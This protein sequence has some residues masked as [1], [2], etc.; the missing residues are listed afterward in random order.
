MSVKYALLGILSEKARHGYD[1]K[2]AFEERVGEFWSLNYGQI[3]QTLDRLERDGLVLR[4]EEP[5]ERRPDRKVYR[6]T[7]KGR[8]E[9]EEWL[10]QPVTRPRALR[11]ELFIK[12][13]FLG[14]EGRDAVIDLIE[15]QKQ[16]Y[17]A[18]MRRLTK[19]KFELSRRPDREGLLVTELLMDAA[20]F[21]AEAD[22]RWLTH[23]AQKLRTAAEASPPR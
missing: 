22:V 12:M 15:R 1:L 17:L 18:H 23:C 4:R 21:H 19:R 20:L 16:V 14:A 5:Q 7:A 8:R 13:L 2:D 10:G 3:Y 9:L 6:I 11:D